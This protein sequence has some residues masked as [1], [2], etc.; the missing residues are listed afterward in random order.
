[1]WL[2]LLRAPKSPDPK[3]DIGL[4]SFAY[5]VVPHQGRWQEGDVVAEAFKFNFPL[6]WASNDGWT[7]GESWSFA[8]V[9]DANL[10]LD[11]IKRAEDSDALIIRLYEC[12]GSRGLARLN[13]GTTFKSAKLSN[14]LEAEGEPLNIVDG[15]VQVP[16]SPFQII[17]VALNCSVP[18]ASGWMPMTCP[19]M[20][21]PVT[22]K[23]CVRCKCPLTSKHCYASAIVSHLDLPSEVLDFLATRI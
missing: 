10:V 5:A 23:G 15:V 14:I 2:S 8:S 17:T 3:A 21:I 7:D 16:Y 13:L 12:H 18:F 6:V 4:H 22:G 11:T 9:D 19:P 20:R 1:M